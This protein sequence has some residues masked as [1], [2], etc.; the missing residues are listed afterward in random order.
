MTVRASNRTFIVWKGKG[1]SVPADGYLKRVKIFA[2]NIINI[3]V[4][5][6][7]VI[8]ESIENQ[9]DTHV[10]RDWGQRDICP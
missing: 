2:V 1:F 10:A 8:I 6:D 9:L 3:A 5:N 7:D 4:D